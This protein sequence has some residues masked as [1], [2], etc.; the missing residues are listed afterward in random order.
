MTCLITASDKDND[1]P[2][3]IIH[4]S[5]LEP[6]KNLISQLKMLSNVGFPVIKRIRFDFRNRK[7]SA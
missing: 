6:E 1:F 4:L 7:T 3:D 2:L 5:A